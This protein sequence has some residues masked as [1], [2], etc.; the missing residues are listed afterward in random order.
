MVSSDYQI[1]QMKEV[2]CPLI[3]PSM[4][5]VLNTKRAGSNFMDF[6]YVVKKCPIIRYLKAYPL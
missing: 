3:N 5:R 6:T 1:G 2:S 4:Y